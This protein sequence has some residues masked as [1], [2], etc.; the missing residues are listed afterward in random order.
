[1][2]IQ[3]SIESSIEELQNTFFNYDSSFT[4][5]PIN[6][7]SPLNKFPIYTQ[8]GWVELTWGEKKEFF[9]I[10]QNIE[11]IAIDKVERGILPAT[12]F[13]TLYT[14]KAPAPIGFGDHKDTVKITKYGLKRKDDGLFFLPVI[15][16]R[17]T[18][19]FHILVHNA[20]EVLQKYTSIEPVQ[21]EDF[22]PWLIYGEIRKEKYKNEKYMLYKVSNR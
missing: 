12:S 7:G 2:C 11:E 22:E 17:K 18:Q 14:E 13:Y 4:F 6:Y 21:I 9:S 8:N 19:I 20:G 1:M 16:D 3:V 10:H 5:Q 15:L